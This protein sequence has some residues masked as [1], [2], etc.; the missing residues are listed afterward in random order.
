MR[1]RLRA[2][3]V[4]LATA[5]LAGCGLPGDD[6]LVVYTSRADHLIKA[7]FDAWEE[8]TGTRVRFITDQDG[9][10]I[11]RLEA[12]G[13]NSPADLLITVDAGNLWNARE[14]GLLQPVDSEV[15]REAVPEH[16]RDPDHHWFGLT[17]RART[18]VYSPERVDPGELSTYAALAEPEWEDRLCLRTSR[19]VYNRS[20]VATMLERKGEKATS[21]VVEGWVSNLATDVFSNDTAVMN[22]I[23]AGQCD[24]GIVNTYYYGRQ[25]RDNPDY[26]VGLFWANQ[27]DSGVHLNIS[28]AAVT[29]HAPRR[30]KAR[31]LL[32]WMAGPE[33]QEILAELNLE[34]PVNEAVEPHPVVR[35]WGDFHGD[36]LNVSVAGRRQVEAVKLMN[37]AGYR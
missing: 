29:A 9:A 11:S 33:A 16:L 2:V 3:A 17:V 5:V 35:Q 8:K 27:E 20:L 28:G 23:A 24:V 36:D 25:V 6:D 12:E 10:L 19:K 21:E 4:T 30:D 32:E 18:I 15:L 13:A 14:R 31:D 34:Y 37:R 1:L 22:A 7:V 26:P